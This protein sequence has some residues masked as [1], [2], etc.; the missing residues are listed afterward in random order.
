LLLQPP[1]RVGKTVASRYTPKD[2]IVGES[3]NF[4][5]FIDAQ[6][7]PVLVTCPKRFV[8]RMSELPEAEFAELWGS[9]AAAAEAN[10]LAAGEVMDIRVNAGSFQ[11]LSHL[12]LKIWLSRDAF[13][14]R[15]AAHPRVVEALEASGE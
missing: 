9:V 14:R 8:R 4:R 13:M 15:W 6:A 2:L 5:T 12:H 3:P 10:G 1:P 7:R 11:N